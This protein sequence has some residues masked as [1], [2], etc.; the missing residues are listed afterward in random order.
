MPFI[1]DRLSRIKPSPTLAVAN[2]AKELKAAGMDIIGLGTGEPDFDTPDHIKQAAKAAMDA[3]DTKYT[4]VDGT[5]ALKKAIQA[6]FKRDN[7]LHYD[8]DQISVGT[9]GK[10][11]LYNALMSTV[12]P[13]DEVLIPAPYWVSYPDMTLLAEGT[14][15][16]IECPQEDGFK[17]TAAALEAAITPKTKWL[18]LNSPSNPTGAAYTKEDLR[19]LADVLLKYPHFYIMSDDMYEHLVYDN[20]KFYTI[21][22]V[23]PKLFDRTLT[24]NGV[25][26]SYSMTG[27]RIGYAGG[28]KQLIKTMC[29]IQSQS[30]S[31]PSSISQAAA[32]AALNGDQTFI[33]PWLDAFKDRRDL[34]VR[35][36]NACEGLS[37]PNPEGAFYVY[38][39]CAGCIGKQTPDG[40]TIANDEDF[41]TYLL[42]SVGVACVHGAAFGL[43]PHFRISYAISTETLRDACARIR[44]ACAA[45]T[46]TASMAA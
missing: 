43:S 17:L 32:V 28:P 37:C 2:K 4:A 1:A 14:P 7:D 40:K 22:Q 35:E 31:N 11:V 45:L 41:V 21:A 13:G 29:N 36:V 39:S 20:F 26:K 16:A 30:T 44:K 10:Q 8:L 9:G 24:V 12:N 33:Q 38:P 46:G 42:E 6:K 19:A 23:E 18:I 5:P 34:V 25:S 15:I 27:W 3:G